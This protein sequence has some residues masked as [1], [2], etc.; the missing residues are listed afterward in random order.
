MQVLIFFKVI[1]CFIIRILMTNCI[2]GCISIVDNAQPCT[3]WGNIDQM[4]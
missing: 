1:L 2:Y 3:I 4:H